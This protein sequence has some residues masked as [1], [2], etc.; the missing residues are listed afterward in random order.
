[1]REHRIYFGFLK[2]DHY[3]VEV[4]KNLFDEWNIQDVRNIT[5]RDIVKWLL[6]ERNRRARVMLMTLSYIKQG[7]KVTIKL[8]K[9]IGRNEDKNE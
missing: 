2:N 5:H 1:M 9:T 6:R 8:L 3:F 7:C 4:K